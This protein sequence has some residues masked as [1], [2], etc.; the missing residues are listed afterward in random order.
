MLVVTSVTGFALASHVSGSFAV[1][2]D[3]LRISTESD[4]SSTSRTAFLRG[5]HL[6]LY[7]GDHAKE[8]QLIVNLVHDNSRIPAVKW[9]FTITRLS[10]SCNIVN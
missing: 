6:G 10:R 7:A 4:E 2:C 5:I 1:I 9:G 8:S 3:Y